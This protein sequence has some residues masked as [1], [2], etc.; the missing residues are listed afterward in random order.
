MPDDFPVRVRR[1]RANAYRRAETHFRACADAHRRSET[2]FR[3]PAD[4]SAC[5]HRDHRRKIV[6]RSREQTDVCVDAP[7]DHTA[8]RQKR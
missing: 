4:Q 5:R 6:D 1:A 7:S 2:D 3:A 8:K